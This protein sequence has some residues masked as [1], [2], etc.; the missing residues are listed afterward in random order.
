MTISATIIADS[1][2]YTRLTTMEL[3][4]PRFIHAEFMTHRMF[5]RNA[6]SSRAIPV[7]RMIQDVLDDPAMP[8]HWGRNQKGMQAREEHDGVIHMPNNG[9]LYARD[10]WLHARDH[11]VDMARR[12]AEAGYH[13]Q[14]VNR[15]LEPFA[16]IKVICTATDWEN[17][18]NLRLHPDAQPEINELALKMKLALDASEPRYVINGDWHL[19]YIG[20]EDEDKCLGI[21]R[22][23]KL[24]SASRCARV[25]YD[26]SG[27]G[28]ELA[29]KLLQDGHLSPF[30]HIAT[31]AEG[32]HA[33]FDGW[34]SFRQELGQ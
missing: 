19:P 5:S 10:A 3:K 15:L 16:H 21:L 12:L 13:K 11:A 6:S 27:G 29:N 18:F 1:I 28:G 9:T 32:R 30:E 4:Y 22:D 7:E 2:G 31:P 25:S 23:L 26:R 33:N 17:F 34:K 14:I 20:Y 24:I 8:I